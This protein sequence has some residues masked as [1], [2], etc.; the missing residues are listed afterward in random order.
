MKGKF[1]SQHAR[2]NSV[3]GGEYVNKKDAK[4]A[5]GLAI[6]GMIAL[7]LFCRIDNLPYNVHIFIR[8]KPLIYFS[9]YCEI[10]NGEKVENNQLLKVKRM[11]LSPLKVKK[12]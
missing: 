11:L 12:F 10:R 3:S 5:Q 4:M 6:I 9:D 1:N 8:K 7:H 2:K